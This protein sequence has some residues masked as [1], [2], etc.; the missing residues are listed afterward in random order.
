V[1][2]AEAILAKVPQVP[3]FRAA[4]YAAR[5]EQSQ[6]ALADY[7]RSCGGDWPGHWAASWDE[8]DRVVRGLDDAASF[9]Q[10]EDHWRKQAALTAQAAGR[11]GV[12]A[13][14][15]HRLSVA[16]YDAVRP[17]APNEELSRV[18]SGAALWTVAEALTWAVAEDLLAPRPNPFLPKLRL[19]ELG[20]W[21]LGVWQGAIVV[22]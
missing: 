16:G 10:I 7:R 3:W 6:A 9:W 22:L 4:E 19:F 8:A 1:E 5:D 21:P 11:T 14:M 15:L 18:A 13:D 2:S 12:L 17:D 20:H